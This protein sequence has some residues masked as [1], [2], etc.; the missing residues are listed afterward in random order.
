MV[1]TTLMNDF[2]Y[3]HISQGRVIAVASQSRTVMPHP[4]VARQAPQC[5][6]HLTS[7]EGIIESTSYPYHHQ[8]TL[9][10]G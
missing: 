8:L 6:T 9:R 4:Y 7:R 3:S 2:D 1:R 10:N 5:V